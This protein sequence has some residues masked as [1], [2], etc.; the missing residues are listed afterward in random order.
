[1]GLA[2]INQAAFEMRISKEYQKYGGVYAGI[3]ESAADFRQRKM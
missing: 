3:M 1:M 2:D